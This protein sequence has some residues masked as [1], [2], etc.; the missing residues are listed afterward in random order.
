[1]NNTA[2]I[3][4]KPVTQKYFAGRAKELQLLKNLLSQ[5]ENV[6][7]Y[8]EPKC[9]KMSLIRSVL[10]SMKIGAQNFVVAE[11]DLLRSRTTED[12]LQSYASAAITSCAT[13]EN[14]C[15]QIVEEYL[16]G[17]HFVFDADRYNSCG[18]VISS[19]WVLDDIDIKK[20]LELPFLLTKRYGIRVIMLVLQFHNVLNSPD[21]DRILKVLETLVER[22]DKSCSYIFT[23]SHLNAMR[24]IFDH[25]RW[26]WKTVER[27]NM[28]PLKSVEIADYIYRGFQNTGKVIEKELVI[29]TAQILR[30]NMWYVNHLFSI[31]DQMARGYVGN[32]VVEDAL[33]NLVSIH[34]PRFFTTICN[35]TDFQLSLLRAVIDGETRFSA[36]SIIDR[37]RL[38]SS[39][40]VKRVKDALVKKEVLW[41]DD[42]DIPH[43]EDPLF[44]YWLRKVYFAK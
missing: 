1:M 14:E 8:G 22:G 10:S 37:Y 11:L 33:A 24:E 41:F 36:S 29:S 42:K 32:M 23:G 3:Y 28:E 15:R 6:A 27:F 12:F 44:E 16:G 2:F 30:C 34:E 39:A 9:G 19:T 40:N 5:S 35:L 38:N 20:V 13:S 18:E 7:L 26:F 31:A 25:K 21:S 4:D 17:T 43:I